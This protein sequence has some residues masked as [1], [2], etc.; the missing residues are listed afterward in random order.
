MTKS[1]A[2]EIAVRFLFA[3]TDTLD[4]LLNEEAFARFAEE[5]E[6]FGSTPSDSQKKYIREIWDSVSAHSEEIDALLEQNMH[7]WKLS[8]ISRTARAILKCAVCEMKY[9]A[10]IPQG[11]S[12]NEAVELAK[13]FDGEETASFINGVLGSIAKNAS[14]DAE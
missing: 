13:K 1:E 9:M 10:A 7:G 12:I 5:D 2:R 8:R 14:A 11:V 3:D 6:L 4:E